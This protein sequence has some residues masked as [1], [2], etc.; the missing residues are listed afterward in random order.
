[1]RQTTRSLKNLLVGLPLAVL[2]AAS[3]LPLAFLAVRFVAL[4]SIDLSSLVPTL[5]FALAGAAT[6]ALVGGALGAVCGTLEIP[7]RRWALGLS[8]LLIAAPPAFWWIGLTRVL[9]R[10]GTFTGLASG[11]GFAGLALA[12]VTLLLVL[13]A[14]REIPAAAY[15][16][17]RVSLSP[18]RRV[19]FVLVPLLR[20]AIVAGFLLTAILLLGESEI[21]FLFG[22][23]TSM[24]DIVTTFS[25][26]FDV[27]RTLPVI[28]PLVGAVLALGLLMVRPLFTVLLAAAGGRGISRKHGYVLPTIAV[29]MLP[30]IAILAIAGYVSAATSGAEI[31]WS[32][33]PASRLTITT[34]IVEP[35]M[36][37]LAS[38]AL[39]LLTAYPLR[40]SVVIRPLAIVGLLVFC[41]PAAVVGIGWI[42]VGQQLGGASIPPSAAYVSRVIGLPVLGF[43]IAYARI[44]PSLEDAARLVPLSP[45]RRAWTLILPLVAPSLAA[46]AALTAALIFADRDVASLLLAPGE[47]RLML[48]LYLLSAN[49][50]S[51]VIGATALVTL[52]AGAI[53]TAIAAAGAFVLRVRPRG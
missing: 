14:V 39:A 46:T 10:V 25:Q 4:R 50:P 53:V 22:F 30:G 6:A 34:S 43:L 21:P 24:T 11:S 13:A 52:A 45:V 35:V 2:L 42:G 23:R 28:L 20:P 15:E 17:A 3:A 27:G 48:N 49:A 5:T 12:P 1:V 38:V 16:A 40:R 19:A 26:T 29:T 32:R 18:A 8:V 44:P 9:G 51:A 31:V 37:A 7:G 33:V 47:S 41:V 36:C